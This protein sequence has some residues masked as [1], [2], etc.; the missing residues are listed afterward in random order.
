MYIENGLVKV[1]F[2]N[3]KI[4][5]RR[6]ITDRRTVEVG[7]T[8]GTSWCVIEAELIIISCS[9]RSDTFIAWISQ[10]KLSGLEV[11]LIS[12]PAV[13]EMKPPSISAHSLFFSIPDNASLV[14]DI[15]TSQQIWN[16]S[17]IV[18]PVGGQATAIKLDY[19]FILL[20]EENVHLIQPEMLIELT[21]DGYQV[22]LYIYITNEENMHLI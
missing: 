1:V 14:Y 4:Y 6:R 11:V 8:T 2:I 9:L 15:I 7:V 12:M 18:H 17:T 3:I 19:I 22:G 20:N 10:N 16:E 21:S 13:T 5:E